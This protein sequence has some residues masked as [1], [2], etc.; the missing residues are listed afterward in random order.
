[1]TAGAAALEVAW[2]GVG[3]IGLPMAA[4]VQAAGHA[5][6]AVDPS[7][8]RLELARAAGLA[9][10]ERIADVARSDIAIVMVATPDQLAAALGADGGLLS[11]LAPGSL[12]VVMSTVGPAPVQAAARAAAEHSIG[13]I[14][15]PVTG[16]VSGARRGA[17]TL[18]ASGDSDLLDRAEPVLAPMGRIR[19]CGG[20]VGQGQT[21][22][23]VNQ[24]LC[25]VHLVAAAEALAFAERAGIDP[26]RVL[27]YV[28]EGAAGSWMLGDRGPRML[29]GTDVEVTSAVDLF[30]KDSTLA[31]TLAEQLGFDAPLLRAARAAFQAA[32]AA[33]LGRRDDSR[34]IEQY[35]EERAP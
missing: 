27:E 2:V 18:F 16:G 33:G 7:H 26:A 23:V 24:H 13:L 4:R 11:V 6:T 1:M 34:V 12:C 14:D 17:L 29:E 8:G 5:V 35:Q 15:V 10:A 9:V 21:M 3:A 28:S 20:E 30:V 19:V 31:A 32:A 22:K 25:S